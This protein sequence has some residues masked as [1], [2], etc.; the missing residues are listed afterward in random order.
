VTLRITN[1]TR[2]T[3]L[4][5]RALAARNFWSR[6]IGL[7]GRPRLEKGQA[8][9]LEHCNSIHTA[10]MR[11]AIDAIYVDRTGRVLKTVPDLKPFRMS[12]I[13]RGGHSVIELPAGTIAQ[14]GTLAGDE[15]LF[16]A[17]P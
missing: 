10:F 9:L 5:S 15:L 14:T 16:E 1:T 11:F 7:L 8:L 3:E 6:L 17:T 12:G 13:L 4:A 2:G